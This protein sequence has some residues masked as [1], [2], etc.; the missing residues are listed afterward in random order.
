MKTISNLMSVFFLVIGMVGCGLY[1]ADGLSDD[2][3]KTTKLLPYRER[4]GITPEFTW[5]YVSPGC[6]SVLQAVFTSEVPAQLLYKK[7]RFLICEECARCARLIRYHVGH[8]FRGRALCSGCMH[9]VF[10]KPR[11]PKIFIKAP[12]G[13]DEESTMNYWL[14]NPSGWLAY[15]DACD[16]YYKSLFAP[17]DWV[18]ALFLQARGDLE[19]KEMDL[20]R[21]AVRD[22]L[23]RRERALR[24]EKL[25]ELGTFLISW[26]FPCRP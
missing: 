17:E 12:E 5:C 6:F 9:A 10:G 26:L 7:G 23:S 19:K 1:A 24:L 13:T 3:G 15:V 25:K 11:R 16:Q 2:E 18:P 8:F 22:E 21:Q 14:I 4:E 20:A